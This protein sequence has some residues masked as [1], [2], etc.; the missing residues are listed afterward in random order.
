[1]LGPAAGR[2]PIPDFSGFDP[3]FPDPPAGHRH[4]RCAG[5]ACPYLS[6]PDAPHRDRCH[7]RSPRSARS[8]A[9][10]GCRSAS[11][12]PSIV[13]WGTAA[14]CHLAM[15]APNGLP[16]ASE[17][18]AAVRDLQVEVRGLSSMARQEW[19]VAAFAGTDADGR[20][21]RARR[22]RA[23]RRRRAVAA[24][25]VA[26][27]HLPRLGT[28]AR[29]QPAAAGGARGL[30][31]VPGRPRRRARPRDRGGRAV[32]ARPTTPPS[33]RGCP[34]DAGSPSW[35]ATR[36]QRRRRRRLPA[37][38][39]RAAP[40]RDLARRAR[41]PRPSSPRPRARCCATSGAPRRRRLPMRT[42]RDLAAAVA[43]ARGRGR[44]SSAPWRRDLPGPRHRD[45]P[46]RPDPPAALHARPRDRA[47]G[48]VAEGLPQVAARGAGHRRRGRGARSW[49]RPKRISWPNLLMVVGSL[50]GL[51]LIIGVLTEASGH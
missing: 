10:T 26:L 39:A 35:Q 51:W 21:D 15:G 13:G 33:S 38:G 23:R 45:D 32:R 46:G 49:S 48:P 9:P 2:P 11:S 16:S 1:M 14:A 25:G 18:T 27:L 29:V 37:L 20:P 6:R 7:S 40:G 3:R 12:P 50:V 43:A 44:R 42:D 31:D 24:Q 36:C 17:V 22:L 5:R 34:R 41:A 30:P 47:H 8:S 19:G 28:D 4:R